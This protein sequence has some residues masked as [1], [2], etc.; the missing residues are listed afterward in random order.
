MKFSRGVVVVL[1]CAPFFCACREPAE[2]PKNKPVSAVSN[3][4]ELSAEGIANAS[5]RAAR[6]SESKFSPRLSVLA[7]VLGDPQHIAEVGSRVPG[8][9]A[10]IHVQLG[11]H[12]RRGDALVEIDG[13]ELHQVTLEFLTATARAREAEDALQRQEALVHERVGAV[14][15]LRRAEADAAAT[16][17]ALDEAVE[18]LHFLGLTPQSIRSLS[19]HKPNAE[20][21]SVVRAPIE[22]RVSAFTVSLGQVLT[23]TENIV[24][25]ANID[26]VQLS[27]R[28]FERDLA[29]VALAMPIEA[30]VPSYPEREFTG[31]V[32][33][34]GDLVD[35][36]SH[37]I[38]VRAQIANADGALRP[39]M[40]AVANVVLPSAGRMWLPE[41]AV[42]HE[43]DGA[44]FVFLKRGERIFARQA[45][46][47]GNAVGGFVPVLKGVS[48]ADEVV[49]HG[50]FVLRGELLRAELSE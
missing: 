19:G 15:D 40:S 4:V 35:P 39:G 26:S 9:V 50:A 38:E 18:H 25:I 47:V 42:Q 37:T 6:I 48:D 13:V 8:R 30:H 5:I 49:V 1:A 33:F 2:V 16:K 12:V 31:V 11:D 7:N 10:T 14:Q 43:S 27:L 24:T 44:A 17:A 45:V 36:I 23:G 41:E 46:T 21:R 29:H 22:G 20:H 28:V 3:V 32:Q 34:I